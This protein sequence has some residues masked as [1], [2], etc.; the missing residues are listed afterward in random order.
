MVGGDILLYIY[1]SLVVGIGRESAFGVFIC[2]GCLFHP[3]APRPY[4]RTGWSVVR[5]IDGL[6]QFFCRN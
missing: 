4:I 5:Q 6:C 2:T 1:V 3:S